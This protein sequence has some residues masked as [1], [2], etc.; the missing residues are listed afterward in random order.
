MLARC[1]L[2]HILGI[3]NA[4]KCDR[5]KENR[6]PNYFGTKTSKNRIIS[7]LQLSSNSFVAAFVTI[8]PSVR[9]SAES[10]KLFLW[11]LDHG[12]TDRLKNGEAGRPT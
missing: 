11:Y 12:T 4:H 9:F 10:G 1:N 7:Q 5:L 2:R 3:E 6:C 8:N